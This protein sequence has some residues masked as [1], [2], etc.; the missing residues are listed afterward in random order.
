MRNNQDH[1]TQ[2]K[3]ACSMDRSFVDRPI[4]MSISPLLLWT[5]S[6][7]RNLKPILQAHVRSDAPSGPPK[8]TVF[9]KDCDGFGVRE[10]HSEH[11]GLAS[12]SLVTCAL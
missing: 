6:G 11:L 3:T 8:T 5:T 12:I 4:S 7:L 10:N 1:R 2:R 9:N